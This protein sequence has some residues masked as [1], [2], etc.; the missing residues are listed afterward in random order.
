MQNIPGLSFFDGLTRSRATSSVSNTSRSTS[1]TSPPDTPLRDAAPFASLRSHSHPLNGSESGLDSP[2]DSSDI[3]DD[4]LS[5]SGTA[6]P[7]SSFSRRAA[8]VSAA[9]SPMPG[10]PTRRISGNTT[11]TRSSILSKD[12]IFSAP[13]LNQRPSSAAEI[14]TKSSSSPSA[15]GRD[16]SSSF[17]GRES[18]EPTAKDVA[19]MAFG[20][21]AFAMLKRIQEHPIELADIIRLL[22]T[23]KAILILPT[24]PASTEDPVPQRAYY[25][26]H[27]IIPESNSGESLFVTLSGI[28]GILKPASSSIALLGLATG[29]DFGTMVSDAS[30]PTK[31]SFFDNISKSEGATNTKA[32]DE[33]E[34][35]NSSRKP[36]VIFVESVGSIQALLVDKMI[37]RPEGE[38]IPTHIVPLA[39]GIQSV[40]DRSAARRTASSASS[41]RSMSF[42]EE[43]E[44]DATPLPKLPKIASDVPL[45]WDNMIRDL[46]S[47]VIKLRKS[48]LPNA[49]RYAN[50][51]QRKYDEVRHRFEVYGSASGM[52]NRWTERDF[53][54]VQ[55]WVEAWLCREMYS[56]IFPQSVDGP[57]SQDYLQDEQLQAKIAA[58]NFLDLTLEHLGFV[59]EHP[60][61]VEHIARVV[62]EGGL[63]MQKLALVKSPSDKMNVILSSHRVVVDALNREPAVQEMLAEAEQPAKTPAVTASGETQDP[64]SVAASSTRPISPTDESKGTESKP[65][66]PTSTKNKRLSMPKIMMDGDI[67]RV[68][69]PLLPGLRQ[70][71][72]P[73]D[74]GYE[75]RSLADDDESV[76]RPV[77]MA[78]TAETLEA[79][80][81]S[82]SPD[83]EQ[84]Q[85]NAKDET[86]CD[87]TTEVNPANVALP[88]SP[89]PLEESSTLSIVVPEIVEAEPVSTATKAEPVAA[90]D[91]ALPVLPSSR[92]QYSADVLLPL[93]IFSVVKSNPPMLISNLRYIQ[94]F[95]VQDHLTGELAYCLT[96]MMAVVS[97][98]EELDPQAFGLSSDIRVLSDLSDIH[99][100]TGRSNPAAVPLLNFQ[101]GFD[102]T[103]ALGHKV[104][105]ELVG[106]AEEGIKVISDV[107]Q[108]GYSKFFGRFLTTS[109]GST[110]FGVG[111]P[112][113]QN[114]T[115]GTRSL[116]AASSL[117]ATA[118][119][120]AAASV[121][122]ANSLEEERKRRAAAVTNAMTN[123][124]QLTGSGLPDEKNRISELVSPAE[125]TSNV[126]AV[127]VD[128]S[129]GTTGVEKSSPHDS[130]ME[131]AARNRVLDFLR[132]ADGPQIHFM[133][134]TNSGDLRLS[135][136][137]GLLED[138]QRIGKML[139]QAKKLA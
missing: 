85:D 11:A 81:A 29:Q 129:S 138:Y 28:R 51:F 31:R 33:L 30:G 112:R 72:I 91:S 96:N 118:A 53:D 64:V 55:Q 23:K 59:L 52:N 100:T 74:E 4:P 106:V 133:A 78:E 110:P 22:V 36:V 99:A 67:P 126:S 19:L 98:L 32:E 79:A 69:S 68:N 104:S 113:V 50:E 10:L 128:G 117:A 15:G 16:R 66:S 24:Y 61:D 47:M 63:E 9:S 6:L 3:F 1:A 62:R 84:K 122:P 48:P 18:N 77:L 71:K 27:V 88:M 58:L 101:E 13:I 115:R 8:S 83:S 86:K 42:A 65:S 136:I 60:E 120:A 107:V 41:V 131:A 116:S 105:Q 97:F 7:A 21:Q 87:T 92:K 45:E 95:K 93:L 38:E 76:S 37:P 90:T 139:E 20:T 89:A 94:R 108:D 26:D 2:R 127:S 114:Q 135:D 39:S 25:E 82:S 102:Q 17:L 70:V 125:A 35:V 80:A 137:K 14:S 49:D 134:C 103:K 124:G 43:K 5:P 111:S 130:A 73:M 44:K 109:D 34:L 119:A 132:T 56:V 121:S 40:R 57:N 75:R 12:S 123:A 54:E 46:E